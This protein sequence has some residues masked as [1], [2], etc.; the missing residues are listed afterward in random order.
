MGLPTVAA[1]VV[2]MA[3][4][5]PTLITLEVPPLQAHFFTFYFAC[6][7]SITPPVV[8]AVR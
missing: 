5:I 6:L 1:Y 4:C 7:G 8:Y 3:V 2:A